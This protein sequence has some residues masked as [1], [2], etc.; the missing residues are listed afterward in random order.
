[1]TTFFSIFDSATNWFN[2]LSHAAPFIGSST[3]SPS[4]DEYTITFASSTELMPSSPGAISGSP[5]RIAFTKFCTIAACGSVAFSNGISTFQT[6]GFTKP[7]FA[8]WLNSIMSASLRVKAS[9]L[10]SR[11]SLPFV[12]MISNRL[13]PGASPV[14]LMNVPVAPFAHSK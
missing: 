2:F 10:F 12:P 6:S 1:M 13:V 4:S 9:R 3:V 8:V 11:T 14:E 7:C 5:S